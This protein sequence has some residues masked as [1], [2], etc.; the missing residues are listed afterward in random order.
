MTIV[1]SSPVGVAA[2]EMSAG[3]S[4]GAVT[5]VVS[6]VALPVTGASGIVALCGAALIAIG[7]GLQGLRRLGAGLRH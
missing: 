2:G 3:A 5:G 7:V 6:G 1:A 4:A